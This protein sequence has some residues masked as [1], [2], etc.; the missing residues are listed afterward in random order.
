M[1]SDRFNVVKDIKK[2]RLDGMGVRGLTQD[3]K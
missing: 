2:V 1:E 3:L